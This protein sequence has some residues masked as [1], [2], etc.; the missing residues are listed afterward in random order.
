[1]WIFAKNGFLSIVQHKANPDHLLVRGRVKGDIEHYFPDA[2]VIRLDDADYLYRAV[3]PRKAVAAVMA[4]A[5][6]QIDYDKFKP[7]VT[8]KR[9]HRAYFEIWDTLWQLQE[10][11]APK[12]LGFR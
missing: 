12:G 4:K 9:R 2:R 1:M 5:V 11:L 7:S 10:Q 8:D 6:E 3:T